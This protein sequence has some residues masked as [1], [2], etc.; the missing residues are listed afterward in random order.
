LGATVI[1][2]A[3]AAKERHIV[4]RFRSIGAISPATAI[5]TSEAGVAERIAFRK[6][7]GHEVI[8]ESAPGLYYLDEPVWVAV[9][10]ARHRVLGALL[11]VVV[12]VAIGVAA[13]FLSLR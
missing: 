9:R 4:D 5:S 13:G 1:A 3:I 12:I 2:A 11:V 8:R 7:R 10:R 6:L